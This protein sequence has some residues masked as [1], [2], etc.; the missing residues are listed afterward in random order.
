MVILI[1]LWYLIV[2]CNVCIYWCCVVFVYVGLGWFGIFM[3]L[4]IYRSNSYNY[5]KVLLYLI[6]LKKVLVKNVD[7]IMVFVW[8][9]ENK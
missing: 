3:L 2:S 1:F 9:V 8:I 7:L 4:N 5:Y 6:F